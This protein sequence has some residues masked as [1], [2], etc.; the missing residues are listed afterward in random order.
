MFMT[1]AE[2]VTPASAVR[3]GIGRSPF[4]RLRALLGD[5]EP[6]KP[7]ISL[8]VGRRLGR[9]RG[10]GEWG[11]GLPPRP[12]GDGLPAGPR[13]AL[14]R[15]AGATRRLLHRLSFQSARR[16]RGPPLSP[17]FR[18]PRPPFRILGVQRRML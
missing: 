10:G 13:R 7:A 2:R 15:P 16:G 9:R 3:A 8:A 6:G 11:A 12:R 4:V 1:A 14:R 18:R 17:A 5:S